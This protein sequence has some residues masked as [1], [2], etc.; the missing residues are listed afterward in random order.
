MCQESTAILRAIAI[1]AMLRPR[2][3]ATRKPNARSGPGLFVAA[4]AASLSAHRAEEELYDEEAAK[5][6]L[7]EAYRQ[8][9]AGSLSEEEFARREAE[10]VERLEEIGRRRKEAG[11]DRR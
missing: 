7:F 10:I 4:H 3:A 6:E 8:L 1:A 11:R 9:E 5:A 2:R